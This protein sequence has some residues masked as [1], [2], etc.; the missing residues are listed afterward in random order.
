MAEEAQR[1]PC[2]NRSGNSKELLVALAAQLKRY[3]SENEVRTINKLFS[4]DAC[5]VY[6]L[7]RN[8]NQSVEQ[9]DPPKKKNRNVLERNLAEECQPQ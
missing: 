1:Y 3:N 4:T 8:G 7:L 9:P 6:S 5:K 2:H